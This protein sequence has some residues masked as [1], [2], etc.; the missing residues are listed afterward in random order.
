VTAP[1]ANIEHV[2]ARGEPLRKTADP[3]EEPGD[4]LL[5][6][7]APPSR[8]H[9]AGELRP[10]LRIRDAA[11]L[12]EAFHQARQVLSEVIDDAAH[13]R[14]VPRRDPSERYCMLVQQPVTPARRVVNKD[15]ACRHRAQP[16]A[17]IALVKLRPR[18]EFAAG[19]RS[20]DRRF[21]ESRLIADVDQFGQHCAGVDA[22]QLAGEF[23][24]GEV[25]L[26]R[27]LP[28]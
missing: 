4:Q 9:V 14:D 18:S 5:V 22:E 11:A 25:R 28:R 26:H 17:D 15:A 27:C 23:L 2:D 13:R 6:I 7:D 8:V 3:P 21:E 16:F 10:I 24:R 12:T 19:C 20:L 1:A